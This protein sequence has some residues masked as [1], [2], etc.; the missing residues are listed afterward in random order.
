MGGGD[1]RDRCGSWPHFSDCLCPPASHHAVLLLPLPSPSSLGPLHVPPRRRVSHAGLPLSCGDGYRAFDRGAVECPQAP[2]P[3]SLGTGF[4]ALLLLL[5]I[6]PHRDHTA[7]L[8][9]AGSRASLHAQH[10]RPPPQWPAS[11]TPAEGH[12][13]TRVARIQYA[14]VAGM[15]RMYASVRRDVRTT[16]RVVDLLEA[17]LHT[18]MRCDGWATTSG[19]GGAGMRGRGRVRYRIQ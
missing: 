12:A 10:T 4:P 16:T 2:P 1:L 3:A 8:S 19:C 18:D 6:R 5:L 11:P 15:R 14:Y 7:H 13:H 17:V 9:G